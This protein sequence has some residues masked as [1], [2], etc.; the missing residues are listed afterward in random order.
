MHYRSAY[1]LVSLATACAD[2]PAPAPSPADQRATAAAQR[3][4]YFAD[5]ERTVAWL[6]DHLARATSVVGYA[7]EPEWQHH[8]VGDRYISDEGPELFRGY[9][10]RN[11]VDLDLATFTPM[12]E[13]LM[14][15]LESDDDGSPTCFVPH[16]ALHVAEGSRS[17]DLIICFTCESLEIWD[18]GG[19]LGTAS[20]GRSSAATVFDRY[21]PVPRD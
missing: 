19:R 5:D 16:H 2:K 15:A 8:A 1:L 3:Q 13:A 14:A 21:I 17:F 20:M 10:I 4:R 9:P 6:G 18:R 11:R 7:I 12:R